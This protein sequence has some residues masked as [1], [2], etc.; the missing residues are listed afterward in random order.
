M[1]QYVAFPRGINAGVSMKME[2]LRRVFE[3]L[4][5]EQVKTVLA[6]GNVLFETRKKSE[7][8]LKRELE[9]ALADAFDTRIP[10]VLRTRE[11]LERLAAAGPFAKVDVTPKTRPYVTFLPEEP[12][13][14]LKLPSGTGYEVLGVF[15]RDVCSIVDL[16]RGT[17]PDLMRV[18]D[19]EFGTEVTTRGW[20]TVERV[21]RAG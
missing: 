6:S 7:A 18:L 15:G 14:G 10:V 8:S 5:H 13:R 1:T 11:E 2:D 16:S 17:T 20:S 3:S 19:K 21:L 12:P 9:K 4:G